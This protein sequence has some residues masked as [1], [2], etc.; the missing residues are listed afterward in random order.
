MLPGLGD[1]PRRVGTALGL[2]GRGS[3]AGCAGARAGR[4]SPKFKN[5]EDFA[6]WLDTDEG[7]RFTAPE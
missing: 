5:A 6:A 1:R 4:I 2:A 3:R 7:K